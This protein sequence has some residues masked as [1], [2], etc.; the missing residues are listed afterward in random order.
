MRADNKQKKPAQNI[1]GRLRTNIYSLKLLPNE[2]FDM[3]CF[4]IMNEKIINA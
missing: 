2:F 3:A 1:L 4:A